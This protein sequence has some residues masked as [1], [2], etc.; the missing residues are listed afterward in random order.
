[1]RVSDKQSPESSLRVRL[2]NKFSLLLP[3][4]LSPPLHIQAFFSYPWYIDIVMPPTTR[5]KWQLDTAPDNE[6]V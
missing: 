4:L 1:M 5:K 2:Q 3:S 6:Y